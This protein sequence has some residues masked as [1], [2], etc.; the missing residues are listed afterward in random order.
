[1]TLNDWIV[2]GGKFPPAFENINVGK[3]FDYI[4]S[5][6]FGTWE[7]SDG[8]EDKMLAI[9]AREVYKYIDKAKGFSLPTIDLETQRTPN[10]ALHF[11]S[12]YDTVYNAANGKLGQPVPNYTD[13]PYAAGGSETKTN[14]SDTAQGI[15]YTP[16]EVREYA[17]YWKNIEN[18][19]YELLMKF[20]PCFV[21]VLEY[22]E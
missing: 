8:F 12:T 6:Y 9:A 13:S 21:G 17:E 11:V 15:Y 7:I 10:Q 18:F 14:Y 19:N 16:G 2:A 4:F 20:I 5:D 22:Y 3:R 1:M